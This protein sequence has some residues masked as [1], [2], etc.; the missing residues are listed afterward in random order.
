MS[1]ARPRRSEPPSTRP[2]RR[3]RIAIA[4]PLAAAEEARRQ[5]ELARAYATYQRLLAA[6]GCIDFGDQV[7]LALRLVRES[8]AARTAIAGRFRYI[9]VDEFQDTNRAQAELVALLAERPSER[10]GRGR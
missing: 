3:Q 2:G 8:P 1:R 4:T 7:S 10:H 5:D 6:N 9:L